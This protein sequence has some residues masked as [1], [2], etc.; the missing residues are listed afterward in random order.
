M[1]KNKLEPCDTTPNKLR[2][3]T[4]READKFSE[5]GCQEIKKMANPGVDAYSFELGRFRT[6]HTS[7]GSRRA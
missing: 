6:V 4:E 1:H 3:G 7:L 5:T 2:A